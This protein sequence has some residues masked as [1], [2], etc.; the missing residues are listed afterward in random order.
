MG[1][2]EICSEAVDPIDVGWFR[3]MFDAST[4]PMALADEQGLLTAANAAYCAMVGRSWTEIAGRSSR[5]FTHP[6]D[7]AAHHAMETKLAA[8]AD[9]HE[10]HR[11]EKRYIHP[12]GSVRWGWVSATPVTG[13]DG[14]T[15]TMAV[16]H[17][18]TERRRTEDNLLAAAWT[19][20]LTGLLNRRGW[21]NRL[22]RF[23]EAPVRV[24]TISLAVIDLDRFKAY[25]DTHGHNAGDRLLVE[26]AHGA[27]ATVEPPGVV[28]RWGGEEF[29]LALP[30]ADG[31]RAADLLMRLA[32]VVPDGQTF[33]AG[34]TTLRADESP[35]DC[36]ARAD[37]LLYRAK[38]AGPGRVVG[39]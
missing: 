35:S 1:D 5:D 3:A 30:H 14:R 18:T 34:H 12:D 20:S 8:A 6:D 7:I 11:E 13:P 32:A 10:A 23:D 16:V 4:V 29:A 24:G 2:G 17:D 38:R 9:R 31:T 25:N 36:F 26:F 15:W 28:A 33:C 27:V 22:A 19:D 37:A 21:E 39:D